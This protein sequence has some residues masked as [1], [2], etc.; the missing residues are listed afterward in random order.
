MRLE[1]EIANVLN[2]EC[3]ENE[4][5]TPDF[6][7]AQYLIGCLEV[8]NKTVIARDKWYGWNG[9]SRRSSQIGGTL[10]QPATDELNR[11]L[12]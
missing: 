10:D 12:S 2:R 3:L 9:L 6:L 5:D 8:W 4:S 7:L 11:V 1:Q